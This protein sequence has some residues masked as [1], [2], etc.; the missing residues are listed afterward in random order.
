MTNQLNQLTV[1]RKPLRLDTI[2]S[3]FSVRPDEIVR[4]L[5]LL[6]SW[7]ACNDPLEFLNAEF[8]LKATIPALLAGLSWSLPLT[9]IASPAS[10]TSV[11]TITNRTSTC[12]NIPSLDFQR[13]LTLTITSDEN[14]LCFWANKPDGTAYYNSPSDDLWKLS[15]IELLAGNGPLAPPNPCPISTNCSY[16]IHYNGPTY[17]CT[18]Q[19]D[20]AIPTNASLTKD[21]LVP[22]GNY[23]YLT[24]QNILE[25]GNGQPLWWGNASIAD[26]GNLT[27]PDFWVGWAINTT[28][29]LADPITTPWDSVWGYQMDQKVMKCSMYTADYTYTLS[30]L[31]GVMSIDSTSRANF[32]PIT[33]WSPDQLS[34]Y[35]ILS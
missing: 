2:D 11:A 25:D 35:P 26:V 22:T 18:D 4:S 16:T 33:S 12:N 19:P 29:P 30:W 17:Q 8:L 27:E 32:V 20:F 15:T 5:I 10:L 6:I 13:E 23:S 34:I 14:A 28:I 1:K 24:A 21:L 9:A 7:Q 3:L 31:N